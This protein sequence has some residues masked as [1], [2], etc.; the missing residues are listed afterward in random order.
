MSDDSRRDLADT[1][2]PL[3]AVPSYEALFIDEYPKMVALAAAVSGSRVFAEDLAQEAMHRLDRNWAKVQGFQSP[4][5]WVRRVTINLALSHRKRLANEAKARLRLA[6]TPTT[7]PP[8][9]AEHE[10]VWQA[11]AALPRNQRAAVALHY[12]EDRSIEEI[13]DILD[14]SPSTARVHLH[15]GRQK[16]RD[17]LPEFDPRPQSSPTQPSMPDE[18]ASK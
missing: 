3:L 17:Q 15:R 1:T 9:A 5:G 6:I 7:L 11:V 12:L 14:I 18:E 2:P 13:A 8:I 4:G 10:P 16:L